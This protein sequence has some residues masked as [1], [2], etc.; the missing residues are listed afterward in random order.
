MD[1]E[2]LNTGRLTIKRA[3]RDKA[4]VSRADVEETSSGKMRR[5]FLEGR[6]HVAATVTTE[7][8]I[9]RG[10]RDQGYGI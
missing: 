10:L 5:A 3:V 9:C 4:T 6:Q 1:G 7:T 8:I 2:S